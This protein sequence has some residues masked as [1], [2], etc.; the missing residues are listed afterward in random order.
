MVQVAFKRAEKSTS[1]S[2]IDSS[3][4]P[5]TFLLPPSLTEAEVKDL[6]VSILY[7]LKSVGDGKL[8]LIKW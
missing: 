7:I 3:S 2:H 8:D 4:T 6:L 5:V 1:L